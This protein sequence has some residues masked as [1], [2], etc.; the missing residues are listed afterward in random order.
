MSPDPS[1]Q[2]PYLH[3]PPPEGTDP[4]VPRPFCHYSC[5][6]AHGRAGAEQIT[7]QPSDS[8]SHSVVFHSVIFWFQRLQFDV[9][10]PNGVLLFR[11]A[12]KSIVTYG[13]RIL[14][15]TDIP[16]DKVYPLKYPVT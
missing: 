3:R 7:G 10:S 12:S 5:T 1:H 4:V 15:V 6:Q 11:E 2:L 16:Q 9:T 14:S 8:I 13:E